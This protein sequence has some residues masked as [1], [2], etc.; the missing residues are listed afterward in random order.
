MTD[1]WMFP[2]GEV[3]FYG[4]PLQTSYFTRVIELTRKAR[5]FIYVCQYVFGVSSTR[6]WQRSNKVFKAL[7][8]AKRNGVEVKVLLDGP[9]E[10]SPNVRT[11]ITC[12]QRFKDEGIEVRCL[13]VNKTLHLKFLIFDNEFFLAGS[14]NLTN[15]SLYSPFELTFE[16]EDGV[17]VNA[18][19]IYF[20]AMFNG[21]MSVPFFDAFKEMRKGVG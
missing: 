3:K 16:C 2:G 11:N 19:S 15:S 6:D 21:A 20:Q 1:L 5:V 8:G 12:A 13:N 17:L 14:H 18:A 4:W 9:R 7:V 10:R